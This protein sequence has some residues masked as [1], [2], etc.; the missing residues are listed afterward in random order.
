M[1][2]TARNKVRPLLAGHGEYFAVQEDYLCYVDRLNLIARGAIAQGIQDHA[3]NNGGTRDDVDKVL[4]ESQKP[5]LI[6]SMQDL[7]VAAA[8]QP[9]HSIAMALKGWRLQWAHFFEAVII[10]CGDSDTACIMDK[11]VN[12]NIYA[13]ALTGK[14]CVEGWHWHLPLLQLSVNKV[15]INI[16]NKGMTRESKVETKVHAG[17]KNSAQADGD[18]RPQFARSKSLKD[19]VRQTKCD[20][21]AP[22]EEVY[23]VRRKSSVAMAED[24]SQLVSEHNSA[25]K[26]E[27]QHVTPRTPIWK[28]K[29]SLKQQPKVV[30]ALPTPTQES[31][32]AAY[33]RCLKNRLADQSIFDPIADA[34]ERARREHYQHP[35]TELQAKAG[36]RRVLAV[37]AFVKQGY[38]TRKEQ[39]AK[40][41][42]QNA[43]L[44][45]TADSFDMPETR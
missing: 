26:Q 25:I 12:G 30:I 3:A 11:T 40:R 29:P 2:I 32:R 43:W 10:A 18:N 36:E 14:K 39:E 8:Q 7:T 35:Q 27:K 15:L 17:R 45:K 41:Q 9:R 28:P 37:K 5:V 20:L 31:S 38:E 42:A 21:P 19:K 44:D 22:Q 1:L 4:A 34:K 16:H 33:E 13:Q 23:S 6:I 24:L